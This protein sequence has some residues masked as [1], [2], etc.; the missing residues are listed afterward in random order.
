MN[1]NLEYSLIINLS[2]SQTKKNPIYQQKKSVNSVIHL[3]FLMKR[4]KI[5]RDRI[6]LVL[7]K[8]YRK[9]KNLIVEEK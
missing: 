1:M 2:T 4:A 6:N 3:K 5:Q 8:Q 7:L 9:N